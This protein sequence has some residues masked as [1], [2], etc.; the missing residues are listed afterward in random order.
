[1]ICTSVMGLKFSAEKMGRF[2]VYLEGRTG[3]NFYDLD[4]G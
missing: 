4:V 1:V 3:R 2:S